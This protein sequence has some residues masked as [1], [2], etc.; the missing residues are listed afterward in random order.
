MRNLVFNMVICK[1]YVHKHS[2]ARNFRMYTYKMCVKCGGKFL[3]SPRWSPRDVA[4]LFRFCELLRSSFTGASCYMDVYAEQD[5][6]DINID[7]LFLYIHKFLKTS[8]LIYIYGNRR[9]KSF[10][11]FAKKNCKLFHDSEKKIFCS[12]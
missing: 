7:T 10:V 1:F 4:P 11:E 6:Y 5:L 3:S 12:R 9:G 2:R 8:H